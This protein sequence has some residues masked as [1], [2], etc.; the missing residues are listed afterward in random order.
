[1]NFKKTQ[2]LQH[3]RLQ[4]GGQTECAAEFTNNKWK[5]SEKHENNCEFN[6]H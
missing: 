3:K 2:Q 4:C 6:N 1:M 5:V